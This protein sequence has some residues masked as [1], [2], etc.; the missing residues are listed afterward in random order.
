ML[1]PFPIHPWLCISFE[2]MSSYTLWLTGHAHVCNKSDLR[3]EHTVDEISLCIYKDI[4]SINQCDY[5]N[6]KKHFLLGC[7]TMRHLDVVIMSCLS[8]NLTHGWFL[9]SLNRAYGG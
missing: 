9:C 8:H 2:F 1:I 3:Q 7:L 6:Q 4:N 5:E